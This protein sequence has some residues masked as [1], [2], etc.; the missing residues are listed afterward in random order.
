MSNMFR[1]V[2]SRKPTTTQLV[3]FI[4][5]KRGRELLKFQAYRRAIQEG[6]ASIHQVIR[7]MEMDAN[8]RRDNNLNDKE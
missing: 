1:H 5:N 2:G 8:Q 6:A 7:Q 4:K 3:N